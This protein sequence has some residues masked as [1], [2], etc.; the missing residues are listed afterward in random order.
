MVQ[1]LKIPKASSRCLL[2]RTLPLEMQASAWCTC[3]IKIYL[4]KQ[5]ALLL[6]TDKIPV[7]FW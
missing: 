1:A 3:T 2:K 6:N 7:I 4:I 5:N